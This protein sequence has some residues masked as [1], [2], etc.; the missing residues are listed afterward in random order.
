[1]GQFINTIKQF[2]EG[3]NIENWKAAFDQYDPDAFFWESFEGGV[4]HYI[5]EDMAYKLL[6]EHRPG[7]GFLLQYNAKKDGE[8]GYLSSLLSLSD[9][10]KLSVF[11][12]LDEI[13][14]PVG[15]FLAPLEALN[16]IEDFTVTPKEPSARI[17]WVDVG[18]IN[19]PER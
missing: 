1:M 12:E 6:I 10:S 17:S 8:H 4:I 13:Y 7:I 19:W 16:V 5:D 18:D 3:I 14:Y 2:G 11:S 9:K 15:C